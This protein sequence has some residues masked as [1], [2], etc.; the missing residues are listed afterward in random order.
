MILQGS[1]Q[2]YL[3]MVGNNTNGDQSHGK[4]GQQTPFKKQ[5]FN[6]TWFFTDNPRTN[7][8]K[9]HE[10]YWNLILQPLCYGNFASSGGFQPQDGSWAPRTAALSSSH[11]ACSI[12]EGRFR[13]VFFRGIFSDKKTSKIH[14]GVS[15][16][17]GF[18]PKMDGL[19]HGN[20]YFLNGW[21]GGKHPLF[22]ETP[23]YFHCF[24]SWVV[25]PTQSKHMLVKL[26]H[27]PKYGWK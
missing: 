14:V 27:F 10:T 18:S 20:P 11:M 8:K 1:D 7:M 22:K 12:A 4:E 13:W 15:L 23:I 17:G 19:F 3:A 26:D 25:E 16:N 6:T 24:T 21:F 9:W 5:I 2:S